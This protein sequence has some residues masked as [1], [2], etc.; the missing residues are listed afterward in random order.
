VQK[1][2]VIRRRAE[3]VQIQK[4]VHGAKVI[5]EAMQDGTFRTVTAYPDATVA[6]QAFGLSTG[7]NTAPI[8]KNLAAEVGAA[9][10]AKVNTAKADAL[11]KRNALAPKA[12]A[13]NA[14][15]AESANLLNESSA[16]QNAVPAAKAVFHQDELRALLGRQLLADRE[17]HLDAAGLLVGAQ[18]ADLLDQLGV[19]HDFFLDQVGEFLR[20]RAYG[21]EAHGNEALVNIRLLDDPYQLPG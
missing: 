14:K 15:K 1:Q 4:D 6:A 8:P 17:T 21:I 20:C 5:T 3:A 12:L 9:S 7:P 18:V 13:H 11:T 10:L 16:A 19:H 2:D